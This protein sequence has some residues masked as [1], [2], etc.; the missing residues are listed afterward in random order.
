M[1]KVRYSQRCAGPCRSW[2]RVGQQAMH[3][4]GGWWCLSC[5]HS[6]MQT[7]KKVSALT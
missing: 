5:A 6:H 3:L 4:H 1:A 7:C 2:L